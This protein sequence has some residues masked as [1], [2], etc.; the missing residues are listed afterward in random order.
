[1]ATRSA[2]AELDKV[3]RSVER[4]KLALDTRI[5][6]GR[7]TPGAYRAG[8]AALD[9]EL[10]ELR[11]AVRVEKILSLEKVP[12]W[13]GPGEDV[14]PMNAHLRRIWTYVQLDPGM[15]VGHVLWRVQPAWLDED[16]EGNPIADPETE[17]VEGGWVRR[18]A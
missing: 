11:R 7:I 8:I 10:A 2:Q 13:P 5:D 4:R 16:A 15:T 14:V 1:M 17:R 18:P 6:V 3:E 9:A 12:A